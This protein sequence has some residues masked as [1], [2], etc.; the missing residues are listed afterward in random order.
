[1]CIERQVAAAL[2]CATL[3]ASYVGAED[4]PTVRHDAARS[5]VT[6]DAVAPPLTQAWQYQPRHAPDPAWGDPNPRPVGGWFG[7][8]EGRRVHF[9]DAFHVAVADGAVYFASSADG[10]V[11]SLDAATGQVRWRIYTGG[12]VRLAPMVADGRV[13]VGSDDGIVYCLRASDGRE[14]WTFRAAPNP[15]KVLGSGKMVSLWPIRTGVLVDDGV[16]YVG[17]G[18]FPAEGV[19]LYALDAATGKKLW[20]NDRGGAHPQSRIS[21]QGY[22]L[23]SE[24]TLFVPMGR[25]S[26]A[27]FSRKTGELLHQTYFSHQIGGA[28]ALLAE[29]HVVTGTRELMAYDGKSRGQ[30]AWYEGQQIVIQG[31]MSYLADG[32][33]L[34]AIDRERYP[35]VSL[36]RRGL[37]EKELRARGGGLRAARTV[38]QRQKALAQSQK[39][40]EALEKKAAALKEKGQ[41]VPAELQKQIDAEAKKLAADR[42][43]LEKAQND[44]TYKSWQALQ[45]QIKDADKAIAD[46]VRWETRS[47]CAEALILAG[48]TLFAGGTGNVQAVKADSGEVL[49]TG[50]VE[51]TARGLAA[52]DGRLYV[53]TDAGAI[54]CF[55]PKGTKPAG[56]LRES[57]K[58]QPFPEED[59]TPLIQAAAEHALQGAD[60]QQ[61]YALVLGSGTG[62]LVYELATRA[63]LTVY[64]IEPDPQKVAKSRAALQAAGL[65]GT[66]VRIE[67][68]DPTKAPYADYFANLIVSET[69]ITQG[70]L[71][72]SAAEAFRMLKPCGGV[73][74]IGQ[75]AEATG[76]VPALSAEALRKWAA[77]SELESGQVTERAGPWLTFTRGPLP[78]AGSWTHQY[79]NPG[80]TT[81]SDDER[82][83]CPLGVLWFGEPGPEQMAERHRRAAAPLA[84]GGRIFIQGEGAANRI[85]GGE[86]AILC[87]DAYNGVKL[88]DR[89]VQGALRVTISHNGGNAAVNQDSF[90][91]AAGDKCLR[92]DADT[93]ETTATYAVPPATDGKGRRWGTVAVVGDTLYGSRSSGGRRADAV[94]ARDLATGKLRWVYEANG[95]PQGAI[96]LGDG[97]MFLATTKVTP[98][99][100]KQALQ[101]RRDE[102][103][104]LPDKERPA[105]EKALQDAPVRAII[106]LDTATGKPVWQRPTDL[107]GA[108]GG[109]YWC[110]LGA[111]YNNDVLMLFGVYADG[112]Y[113]KQFFAGKFE[114]RRVVSLFAGD[115][116]LLWDKH[117]GYRVRP[118]VIGDTFH[119]EPWAYDLHTGRQKM[120]THPITGQQEPWQFARPGHHCGAPA[121]SPHV[122]LFRSYTLGWYDLDRD[123][124]TKHFASQRPGCWINFIPANGLLMVPEASSGCMCPFPNSTSIVFQPKQEE[125]GWAYFSSPG[126][127][128]PV[129][130]L[131]LNLG[132]PG[133]RQAEDGTLWLGYPRPGG[134][135]VMQ[136]KASVALYR[137]G[138]YIRHDPARLDIAG[139][140]DP[141]VFRSAARG[142]RRCSL[143]LVEPGDGAARYTVRLAFAELDGAKPGQRVFDIQLQGKTVASGVDVVKEAGGTNRALVKEF[144]GIDVSDELV[145]ELVAKADDPTPGQVPVLQGVEV[146]RETVLSVGVLLPSFVLQDAKPEQ[147]AQIKLANFKEQPFDGA[148]R[149]DAPEGFTVTP[150][151]TSLQLASGSRATLAVTARVARKGKRRKLP[152]AVRLIR[153]DGG[154]EWTGET[155]I[156]YLGTLGRLTA[157]AAEDAWVRHADPDNNRGDERQIAVDGGNPKFGDHGHALAYLKFTFDLPG[158]PVRAR[159]RLYNAGNPT[160][161]SG[162]VRLTAAPWSEKAVTYNNRPKPGTELVKIG[163]V[164]A[165]QVVEL[166]LD[167]A[168][169][170]LQPKPKAQLS[171]VIEPTGCDGVNYISREG[172]KPA[173]LIIEYE[174]PATP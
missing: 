143:P 126:E 139:T 148:L 145:I 111:I 71:P 162:R 37:R 108:T 22:L 33:V 106:A 161:D 119:A 102:I 136:L 73:L 67:Q 97:K 32:R 8:Q 115:G 117:I 10:Q 114:Q 45:A 14:E 68:G 43:A 149:L 35:K 25:V 52:A 72:G 110:S 20:C 11:C 94:F 142:L 160:G 157:K 53:S 84:I 127:P 93:G 159:L 150:R 69:A 134:S 24:S 65:Y 158:K 47:D 91:I 87:Y 40:T 49:W 113:W 70:K 98:E 6:G 174:A 60:V 46:C 66:R 88:W 61:G 79:A 166:A 13:Y 7:L 121:A 55:G 171:L 85:G 42:T 120:R 23:A 116:R 89:R 51:G 147:Q 90:F 100:R 153:K 168:K 77:G 109:A 57:P 172:G 29:G 75:P 104:K 141:W 34:K 129:K 92:L 167:P 63:E 9:D 138:K 64:G 155:A 151:E 164:Q 26:P 31:N 154:V 107:T 128:T 21:P 19:Y 4:W 133:D 165:N 3:A 123:Y 152:V 101:K 124:G 59:T 17:A 27:G 81:C 99:Q 105:A 5:G 112:H 12:P 2:L 1:M 41:D 56:V 131:A 44:R 140:T 95:I 125:R 38:Q 132:A 48:K 76:K 96:A 80:N 135:L 16:A 78:G 130:H 83:R 156:D 58:P 36:R 62:R 39:A 170:A 86:N 169:L 146:I 163:R 103:A 50:K 30:F 18:I 15:R 28:Y 144:K 173:E 54:I 137:G 74:V 118:I 122:M 82:V